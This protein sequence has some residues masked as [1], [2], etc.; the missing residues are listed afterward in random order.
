MIF[1]IQFTLLVA[2]REWGHYVIDM[3]QNVKFLPE[4]W[5]KIT[6]SNGKVKK[7]RR[8]K[9]DRS[10]KNLKKVFFNYEPAKTPKSTNPILLQG[11]KYFRPFF[12]FVNIYNHT[13]VSIMRHVL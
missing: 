10:K 8:S 2:I 4:A 3:L 7:K 5:Y 11:R 1:V 12:L 13:V 9:T 6:L